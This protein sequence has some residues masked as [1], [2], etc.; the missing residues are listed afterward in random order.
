MAEKRTDRGDNRDVMT[1]PVAGDEDGDRALEHVA[2]E[3]HRR[4]TFA[5]GAEHVGGAD[6]AGADAAQIRPAGKPRQQNAEWNRAA[7]ITE[8]QSCGA[9]GEGLD[10][11]GSLLVIASEAKQSSLT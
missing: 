9:V 1:E 2:N 5:A 11:R 7:Q 6:I 4:Q 3:R 8:D 10:H